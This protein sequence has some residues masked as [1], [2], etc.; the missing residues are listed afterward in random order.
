MLSVM[1]N[2]NK[3]IQLQGQ[4]LE[5]RESQ[6]RAVAA[7]VD[8]TVKDSVKKSY[9]QVASSSAVSQPVQ[10]VISPALLQRTVKD[11]ADS[12]EQSKNIVVFGLE[13]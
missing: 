2:D 3:V 1:E 6:L 12:E 13:E 9:S 7:T 8:R 11:I 4:L 10:P 5:N